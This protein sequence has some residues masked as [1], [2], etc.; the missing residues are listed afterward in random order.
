MKDL[1]D[2]LLQFSRLNSEVRE[3]ELVIMEIALEDVLRN[4]KPAI[5]ESKAHITHDNLPNIIGDHVDHP[6][7]AKFDR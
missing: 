5:T 4:L 6:I 1:I 3:F 2:D 7:A